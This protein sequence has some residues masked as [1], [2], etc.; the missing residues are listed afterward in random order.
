MV[1]LKIWEKCQIRSRHKQRFNLLQTTN[2]A[3]TFS[4]TVKMSSQISCSCYRPS[5]TRFFFYLASSFQY[6]TLECLGPDVPATYL[7]ETNFDNINGSFIMVLDN[8]TEAVEFSATMAW[9]TMEKLL[10]PLPGKEGK[11]ARARLY[12]PPELRKED[13][14]EYPL[15]VHV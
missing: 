15:V 9:P 7:M 3:A 13:N 14:I 4:S 12:L 2:A 8:N 6:Y 11:M 1:A 5:P 10:V